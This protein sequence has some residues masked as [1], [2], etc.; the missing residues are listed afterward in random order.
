MTGCALAGPLAVIAAAGCAGAAEWPRATPESQGVDAGRLRAAVQYMDDR[1][2]PDG[3]RQLVILRNGWLIHEG[4]EVDAYHPIFS[5]T[6]TFTSTVLGLLIDDGKCTLD[7]RVIDVL[8]EMADEFPAYAQIRL[9]HL[10]SMRGGYQGVV[11]GVSDD[12]PWGDPLAYFRPQPPTFEA[13]TQIAYN[14]HD[15]HLLGR[16][17]MRLSGE[18]LADVFRRRIAE[19]IGMAQW[20]WGACGTLDGLT[21]YNAAGTPCAKGGG[22][23]RT[24]A[25]ELARLGQLYLNG[26]EWSGARVLSPGFVAEASRSHIPADLPGRS[27]RMLAGRYGLYWWTNG[28]RDDDTRPW[29][30]APPGA[31]AAHGHTANYCFVIP[32]WQMVIVRLGSAA[33]GRIGEDDVLWEG[34]FSRLAAAVQERPRV[35]R[36]GIADGRW[37]INGAVTYTGAAAE[38]LLLNVRMVNA[39]FEDRNRTDFD[40]EANTDEFIAALPEYVRCGVRA[41]TLN[42]QG[43][44]PD[45]EG[46]LNSAFE[47]DGTLRTEYVARV[48]RVIEACDRERATV[49]LG[50]FYQRQDQVLRDE[51]AVREGVKNV[52]GWLAGRGLTNVLLEIANEFGHGGFDHGVLR[53]AD[54][55]V[56]LIELARRTAAEHG[57]PLLVSTSGLGDARVGDRVAEA[58]DFLLV[59]LNSTPLAEIP[60]R[61]AALRRFGKPIVVNEDDKVGEE[62]ARAAELCVEAGVSWGY[63]GFAVNQRFPFEFHGAADDPIVYRK[64]AGLSSAQ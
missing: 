2:Q 24:T 61:L 19:P 50:C 32:E 20:E 26:G 28:V 40:P 10:A 31:F 25:L 12:Q 35:T 57:H 62:A 43:G 54:G 56:G 55:Q 7:T 37:Q 42:L 47:A 4:P 38:G 27:H 34:F 41:F 16:V 17:L 51:A 14:D 3:A 52:V 59:H 44:F 39:V 21:Y 29:P 46:A 5:C 49:I 8:P 6:K 58:S 30:S 18:P 63:M 33:I 23:V 60:N 1:F 22:G 53:S 9:R 45:Y 11:E 15:V 36:I 13:G 48:E 64:L